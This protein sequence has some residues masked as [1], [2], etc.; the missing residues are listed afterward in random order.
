MDWTATLDAVAGEW[1]RNPRLR[2]AAAVAV[3]ILL[4]YGGL[5]LSDELPPLRAE[6]R[7]LQ[8]QLAS[9]EGLARQDFWLER[10]D[11]VKALLVQLES[12]LWSASSRGLAQADVQGWLA[13][14]LRA[15]RITPTRVQV[16]P[17]REEANR[18]GVWEV[19][20]RVEAPLDIASLLNLLR[21]I[22]AYERLTVIEQ[23]EIQDGRP[24]R[25]AL[26]FKA[27]FR[28]LS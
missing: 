14:L 13:G 2:L 28:A 1:R 21:Y 17:A 8:Q 4:G 9:A 22:E 27:Y 7:R 25:F 19:A 16:E 12:R 20:G 5:L 23:L 18:P 3:A 6:H 15:A 24:P 11:A 26:V 10:R